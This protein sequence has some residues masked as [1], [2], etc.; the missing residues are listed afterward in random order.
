MLATVFINVYKS[1]TTLTLMTLQFRS[2][3]CLYVY[4]SFL[5]DCMVRRFIAIFPRLLYPNCENDYDLM[6]PGANGDYNHLPL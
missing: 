4:R 3:I 6:F 5:C 2:Y 1:I